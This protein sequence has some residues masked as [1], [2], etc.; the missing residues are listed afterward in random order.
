VRVA[1]TRGVEFF[2]VSPPAVLRRRLYHE[3]E[4]EGWPVRPRSRC[5]V[6]WHAAGIGSAA[7]QTALIV[8]GRAAELTWDCGERRWCWMC[9]MKKVHRA[10]CGPRS[11]A[12]EVK[13][14][15]NWPR[16]FDH[17]Q[18]H[19]G[20]RSCFRQCL[21]KRLVPTVSFKLAKRLHHRSSRCRACSRDQLIGAQ[22][23]ANEA[24]SRIAQ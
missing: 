9:V 22:R 10:H 24:I 3:F 8:V 12:S 4:P 2:D 20:L 6:L 18:Q 23:A 13:G 21:R 16:R 19:T 15:V 1:K 5:R 7:G 17:M 14:C 11:G